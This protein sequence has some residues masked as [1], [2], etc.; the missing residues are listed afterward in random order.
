MCFCQKRIDNRSLVPAAF[1][2]AGLSGDRFVVSDNQLVGFDIE[3]LHMANELPI[4][5]GHDGLSVSKP[6]GF[7]E[8]PQ[9]GAMLE[10]SERLYVK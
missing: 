6:A 10:V 8:K 7:C 3:S 5:I 2:V 4:A 9:S 1:Q